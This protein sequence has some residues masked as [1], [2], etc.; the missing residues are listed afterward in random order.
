MRSG[1]RIVLLVLMMLFLC[2]CGGGG[3]LKKDQGK[4][5]SSP[6]PIV[7]TIKLDISNSIISKD[8]P[9]TLTATVTDSTGKL[10][11]NE[12]VT[13]S[14]DDD[15]LGT[16]S[17]ENKKVVTNEEGKAII[18]LATGNIAGAGEVTATIEENI[19][20]K[21]T[22]TMKGDGG[23]AGGAVQVD[24]ALVNA[25]G[26]VIQTINS[27]SKANI[28]VTV[29]GVNRPVIVTFAS[30]VADLP[31]KSQVTRQQGDKWVALVP[32]IATDILGAGHVTATLGSGESGRAVIVIGASNLKM[33]S[34][35]PFVN[36][37]VSVSVTELSAGGTASVEVTI[38]D[39]KNQPF[40]QPIDVEFSS[41]CSKNA[42]AQAE[43]S[44][45]V[46]TV[47]GVATSTYL[48]K[49]CVGDDL[50][51][52]T[53]NAGGQTLSAT[54]VL[55]VLPAN[56]GSIIF[57]SAEP[58]SL[59]IKG[60]GNSATSIIKFKVLD[61]TGNVV[62]NKSVSF[63]LNTRAG[64]LSL[65]PEQAMTNAEGIVQTVVT[66]G[67]VS[68]AARVTAVVDGSVP[69][70]QGQ[71]SRLVVSTGI[72]DQDSFTI[73]PVVLNPEALNIVDQQVEI[74][75]LLADAF[76]NPAPD[77]TVVYFTSEGGAIA[78]SCQT[79]NGRCSVMWRSQLPA[80]IGTVNGSDGESVI[81][82][83]RPPKSVLRSSNNAY[84]G[85]N[86]YEGKYGG[87]V[88]IT[89]STIG[90]ES[91]AD[92][93]GS[94]WLDTESEAQLFLANNNINGLPFDLADP[95]VDY[96]EDGLFNPSQ[97]PISGDERIGGELEE[98]MSFPENQDGVFNE[99]DNK[100]N[101]VLCRADKDSVLPSVCPDGIN[102]KKS[103][104][105]RRSIVL[106][107]SGS[108]AY[109]TPTSEIIIND[110]KASDNREIDIIKTG[111]ARVKFTIS[112]INNQQMP[113]GSKVKFT[114]SAGTIVSSSEIEWPSSNHNGGRDFVVTI[115]GEEQANNGVLF[116][117]VETPSG[118][119]S[120]VISLP[121][122]ITLN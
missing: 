26:E 84:N 119:V 60:T 15:K 63:S 95:Y 10:I 68:T 58:E 14:L 9:A 121:I 61:S 57:M 90:E 6:D 69:T 74:K 70:I 99:A 117:T 77:G 94:G 35:T 108:T 28:S 107:M 105:I 78:P 56:A 85:G 110:D 43:I 115:K 54:G 86:F 44:S 64:G 102:S 71:S 82:E 92:T 1:Y 34:G 80:P 120:E 32:V 47:N 22:F 21:V 27:F 41:R 18:R 46:A 16:F 65:S 76:N 38:L 75:A 55:K 19:V 111:T 113:A 109:A 104:Y 122:L 101:G 66:T 7:K 17:V 2:S 23:S 114:A 11:A 91:F 49:G 48:A 72:P 25:N 98:L 53:A 79:V 5:G 3:N 30:T 29:A 8:A 42:I 97:N 4:D 12:L 81:N 88:T 103:N 112:D 116:V 37:N 59:T 24:V 73:S 118:V 20:A 83:N 106:V 87:R 50:I 40:N 33:G 51:T 89:A 100:Y 45:P 52:V 31:I 13:F 62:A 39:D 67:A 93:N 36:G 96:N